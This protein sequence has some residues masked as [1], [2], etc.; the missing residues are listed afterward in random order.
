MVL[1]S[2]ALRKCYASYKRG[3]EEEEHDCPKNFGGSSKIMEAGSIMNTEG[4]AFWNFYFIIDI[5]LDDNY[6]TM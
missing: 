5:I 2:K 1:Y 6:I 4:Y 3:E